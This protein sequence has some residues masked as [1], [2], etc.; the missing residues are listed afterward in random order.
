MED[1]DKV[2]D[3]LIDVSNHVTIINGE[4][5][6]TGETGAFVTGIAHGMLDA[7]LIVRNGDYE[8]K[9]AHDAAGQAVASSV[10]ARLVTNAIFGP[11]PR[12]SDD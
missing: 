8:V 12:Y 1:R 6:L 10:F 3:F 9:D 5:G 2:A 11:D 7:A 4:K